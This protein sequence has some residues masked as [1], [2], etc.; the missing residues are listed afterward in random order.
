[1]STRFT[2]SSAR[3]A[4]K[5][6]KKRFDRVTIWSVQKKSNT[7]VVK[8]N[9]RHANALFRQSL[10]SGGSNNASSCA[11]IARVI[12]AM[13]AARKFTRNSVFVDFG[14]GSGAVV[15]YVSER[16]NCKCY[17]IERFQELLDF[18]QSSP[19]SRRCVWLQCDFTELPAT[20][21]A[22]IG[23]THV[24]AFD[25]VFNSSNWNMTLL[26]EGTEGLLGPV[27]VNSNGIGLRRSNRFKTPFKE[28]NWWVERVALMW[29]SGR[30][31]SE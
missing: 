9:V 24:F 1:M 8:A 2:S 16:F 18:A 31:P 26:Q 12:D 20:W 6:R 22:S 3:K 5:K 4:N 11:D 7:E 21:L 25:G 27:S 13:D 15:R 28:L 10:V 17:G 29:L 19:S 14:C 30:L 23:A